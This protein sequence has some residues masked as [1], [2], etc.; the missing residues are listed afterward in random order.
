MSCSAV[1][2]AL[3][4]LEE[5]ADIMILYIKLA[6]VP[7]I[8]ISSLPTFTSHSVTVTLAVP[9]E[10]PLMFRDAVILVSDKEAFACP[11]SFNFGN[12]FFSIKPLKLL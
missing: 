2:M 7:P 8:L 3:R 9:S 5:K 12:F 10:A 11:L 4:I 6:I 1:S